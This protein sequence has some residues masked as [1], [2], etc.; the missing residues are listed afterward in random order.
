MRRGLCCAHV[1]FNAIFVCVWP[2][3]C[4]V[5]RKVPTRTT[6]DMS[7]RNAF[8]K[9]MRTWTKA[10]LRSIVFTD[11]SWLPCCEQTGRMMW[12]RSRDDVLPLE[13]K[14]RWNVSSVMIWAVGIDYK[15]PT[16]QELV[17]VA[18]EEWAKLPQSQINA[19]CSH[20]ETQILQ[21]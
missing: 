21:L 4:Y 10:K 2:L 9:K 17:S 12:A 18:K 6:V 5:R 20:F 3:H 16:Q 15:S 19:H 8:A 1:K 11:E 7:K 13:R 14:C